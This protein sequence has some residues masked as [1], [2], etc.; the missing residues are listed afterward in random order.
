MDTQNLAR[1]VTQAELNRWLCA[2]G[3]T[4]CPLSIEPRS[5]AIPA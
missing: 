1:R 2:A 5:V 3:K 4:F